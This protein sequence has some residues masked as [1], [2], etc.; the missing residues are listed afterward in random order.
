MHNFEETR[1][2]PCSAQ[3]MY[4]AVMDIESYPEF[5][6]WVADARILTRDD[7]ELTAELIAELAGMRH[8]FRSYP[9]SSL[10]KGFHCRSL[11]RR[12]FQYTGDPRPTSTG[13][14]ALPQG[15]EGPLKKVPIT[16]QV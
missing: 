10:L 3:D 5:L 12:T 4:N 14:M 13:T 11:Q 7:D 1:V 6:P 8:S 16:T 15:L 2:L 9:G